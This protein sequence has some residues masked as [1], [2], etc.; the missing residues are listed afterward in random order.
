MSNWQNPPGH[1]DG[2]YGGGHQQSGYE[3]P[4]GYGQQPYGGHQP[5]GVQ[6]YPHQPQ[7]NGGYPQQQGY[8]QQGSFMPP[9]PMMAPQ[10]GIMAL[11]PL[12]VGE[13]IGVGFRGL[14]STLKVSFLLPLLT[15]LVPLALLFAGGM[16]MAL[17]EESQGGPAPLAAACF[18]LGYVA[19]FLVGPAIFGGLIHAFSEAVLGRKAN[20]GPAFSAGMK[21]A[22]PMILATLLAGLAFIVLMLPAVLLT[23]LASAASNEN[24]GTVVGVALLS[25][26]VTGVVAV[27][28][29]I[30]LVW[31][32]YAIVMEHA[33]PVS[34]IRRSMQ[35]T[36]GRWWSTFGT[37]I[38][39]S[40][41]SSAI[42]YACIFVVYFIGLLAIV[43]AMVSVREGEDPSGG[44]LAYIIIVAA[45]LVLVY[46]VVC[47][48][49]YPL[50]TYALGSAYL[51]ARMKDEPDLAGSLMSAASNGAPMLQQPGFGGY[52]RY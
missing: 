25:F 6:Q 9:M 34:A 1:N 47:F 31:M 36:R 32:P 4:A 8:P 35:L 40:L 10:P 7:P 33:G 38:L 21:R 26:L 30:R 18:V 2:P 5:Y 16:G 52:T 29:A 13:T 46:S 22:V 42:Q 12:D 11:R 3:Q 44:T 24:E 17:T 45:I 14:K 27:Y 48:L 15:F 49:S 41:V 43:P 39:V 51:S 37:Y 20:L 28:F 50:V 23:A 19:L